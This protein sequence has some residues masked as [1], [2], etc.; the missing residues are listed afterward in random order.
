ML[1]GSL[2]PPMARHWNKANIHLKI[3][4][5]AYGWPP[6]KEPQP[7]MPKHDQRIAVVMALPWQ[8]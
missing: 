5:A 4:L 8:C 1:A 7:W 6:Q 2:W 3:M